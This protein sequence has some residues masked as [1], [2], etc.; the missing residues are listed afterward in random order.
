MCS[1][2]VQSSA[3]VQL[4]LPVL[5]RGEAE[6]IALAQI[7]ED[8]TVVLDDSRARKIAE[9]LGLRQIGTVGL[10]LRAKRRGL[11]ER[12]KPHLEALIA[13]GIYIRKELI[14]AV[15]KEAGE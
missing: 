12:I 3:Q 7:V 13:N 10:L 14:E 11:T 9:W 5:D 4:L 8:C 15:L 1:E 6:V 2:R